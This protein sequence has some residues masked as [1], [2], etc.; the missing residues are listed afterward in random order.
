M[1]TARSVCDASEEIVR[2]MNKNAMKVHWKQ[3]LVLVFLTRTQFFTPFPFTHTHTHILSPSL[4]LSLYPT[5]RCECAS[6]CASSS[7]DISLSRVSALLS[8]FLFSI[9]VRAQ[10][11]MKLK[12]YHAYPAQVRTHADLRMCLLSVRAPRM[13]YMYMCVCV[14]GLFFFARLA[15]HVELVEL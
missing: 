3:S 2:A 8:C 10:T 15:P 4:S 9:Y 1:N 6:M 13:E 11:R 5:L 14:C 7:S 12:M